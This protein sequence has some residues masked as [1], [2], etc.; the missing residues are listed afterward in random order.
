MSLH[1][2]DRTITAIE[3]QKR[4]RQRVTVFLD[5]E[6]GFSLDGETHAQLGLRTGDRLSV[7]RV[8]EI[9]CM[10]AEQSARR[11]ALRYLARRLRSELEVRAKLEASEAPPAIIDR[12][13]TRLRESGLI[14][15]RRF[16]EALIHD[17]AL[18]DIGGVRAVRERLRRKGLSSSV[19]AESLA[20]LVTPE[21]QHKLALASAHRYL[22]R[23][24]KRRG[25][26][27]LLRLRQNLMSYLARRG[28]EW[29]LIGSVVRS[30]PLFRSVSSEES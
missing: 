27:D 4:N 23:R 21:R 15:D 18:R 29:S 10:E 7:S 6:F 11:T 14:D 16:A 17:L 26:P 5:G 13:V 25:K 12:V 24:R 19:I 30:L 8:E 22:Q 1:D 28:F 3:R 9:I 20:R 2:G